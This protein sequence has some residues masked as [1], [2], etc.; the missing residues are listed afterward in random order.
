M[1]VPWEITF[2][3]M[4]PSD[5]VRA[6]VEKEIERLERFHPRITS[7]KVVVEA[8]AHR[9]RHGDLYAVRVHVV[10][11]GA[12]ATAS[13]NPPE[14]HSHEDVY[15]AVRDA[16]KA[17]ARQLQDEVRV[18][19]L[20]TKAHEPPP[21]GKVVRL[22]PS[23]DYGFIETPDKQEVYFHRNAVVGGGFDRLAVGSEVRFAE[24][25]GDKGPQASSVEL[26]GKHHPVQD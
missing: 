19:D 25:A 13:R 17:L 16:F 14:D 7:C 6:R 21:Y 9:K 10:L 23:E 12:E 26:I 5:A 20:R 3:G 15:V 18:M 8:R 22:F 4:D 11:P 1:Q 2:Q 24:S